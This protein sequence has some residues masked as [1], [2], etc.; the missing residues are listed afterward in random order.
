MGLVYAGFFMNKIVYSALITLFIISPL[1][2]MDSDDNGAI[3]LPFRCIKNYIHPCPAYETE[4]EWRRTL[5]EMYGP[6]Q[7]NIYFQSCD[8]ATAAGTIS[9][10]ICL[11]GAFTTFAPISA[12]A[13]VS[14]SLCG[15]GSISASI[16]GCF[17]IEG[18]IQRCC[19]E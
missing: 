5:N 13:F 16:T 14:Q 8:K 6:T 9:A 18:C 11:F 4:E 1:S 19:D 3:Y 15:L 10:M 2:S 12:P 7:T 17:C